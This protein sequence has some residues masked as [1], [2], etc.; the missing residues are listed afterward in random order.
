M[1]KMAERK[2][3][4]RFKY[5]CADCIH[6]DKERTEGND[7]NRWYGCNYG[8]RDR[9]V[10]AVAKDSELKNMGCSNCNRVRPGDVLEVT[11]VLG[12]VCQYL[13]CGTVGKHFKAGLF[14]F[15]KYVT[16]PKGNKEKTQLYRVFQKGEMEKTYRK[17]RHICLNPVQAEA[18][19]RIAKK[20]RKVWLEKNAKSSDRD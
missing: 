2:S 20:R 12:T 11:T 18:G 3:L 17:I 16:E 15:R 8:S 7:I 14:Y 13:F 19:K 6:L 9:V 4:K 1:C 5:S 10:G